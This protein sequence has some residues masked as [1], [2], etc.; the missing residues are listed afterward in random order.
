MRQTY[1]TGDLV[2]LKSTARIGIV[3]YKH[4]TKGVA[5]VFWS[6]NDTGWESTARLV[7][8]QKSNCYKKRLHYNS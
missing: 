1:S 4:P 2:S 5:R 8:I 3:I 7:L 6:E